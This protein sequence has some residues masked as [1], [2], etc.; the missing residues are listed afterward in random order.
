[1]GSHDPRQVK[2]VPRT[3]KKNLV[4]CNSGYHN[5]I[6]GS[7]LPGHD[8][9]TPYQSWSKLHNATG[10]HI[11][12]RKAGDIDRVCAA[13]DSGNGIIYG[14]FILLYP[15]WFQ[16]VFDVV[17]RIMQ[18]RGERIYNLTDYVPSVAIENPFFLRVFSSAGFYRHQVHFSNF[19]DYFHAF[20]QLS[21][22]VF[23]LRVPI[24]VPCLRYSFT[25]GYRS[26]ID[27][28]LFD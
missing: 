22:H 17:S 15:F 9:Q 26:Y 10:S 25:D 12:L 3:D 21:T 5:S 19:H 11:P 24:N 1:M 23:E 7:S 8:K 14:L 28:R 2:H 27:L 4:L 16:L 18:G 20:G 6:T 13:V